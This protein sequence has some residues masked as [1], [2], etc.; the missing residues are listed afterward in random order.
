MYGVCT[1]YRVHIHRSLPGRLVADAGT[2]VMVLTAGPGS[3]LKLDR[4]QLHVPADPSLTARTISASF[5]QSGK[6]GGRG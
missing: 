3:S 6:A 2:G 5:S 1:D 4:H